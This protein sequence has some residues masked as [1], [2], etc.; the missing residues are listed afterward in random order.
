M[1]FMVLCFK[2]QVDGEWKA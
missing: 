1:T 2:L